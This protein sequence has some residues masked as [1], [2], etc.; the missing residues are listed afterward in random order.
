[1]NE[2]SPQS[3]SATTQ[4][5]LGIHIFL[6]TIL[7]PKIGSCHSQDIIAIKTL[8]EKLTG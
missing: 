5:I 2:N 7:N 3:G 1:M 4:R 6:T 8:I